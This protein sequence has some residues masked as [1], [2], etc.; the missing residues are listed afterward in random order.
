MFRVC[1]LALIPSIACADEAT[2]FWAVAKPLPKVEK[3]KEATSARLELIVPFDAVVTIDGQPT[4]KAGSFRSFVSPPISVE[5][6]Y[7]VKVFYRGQEEE[8]SITVWPGKTSQERIMPGMEVGSSQG[9]EYSM[10]TPSRAYSCGPS[11]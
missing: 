9:W 4:Q 8:R 10:G 2:A 7:R 11:G 5:S 1:I 6:F 3:K